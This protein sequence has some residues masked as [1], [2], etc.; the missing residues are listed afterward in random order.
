[1]ASQMFVMRNRLKKEG[2]LTNTPGKKYKQYS[3]AILKKENL[4]CK[5]LQISFIDT[6][7]EK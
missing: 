5:R 3:P 1:M 4:E 6:Y 2:I 7:V